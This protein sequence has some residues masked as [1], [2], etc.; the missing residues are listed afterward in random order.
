M[1]K[2]ENNGAAM[3][4]DLS[5]VL[6]ADNNLFTR[7]QYHTHDADGFANEVFILVNGGS[8]TR[9]IRLGG[10]GGDD[11]TIPCLTSS[12]S[13]DTTTPF[14]FMGKGEFQQLLDGSDEAH[15]Q[16][17]TSDNN[18]TTRLNSC[19]VGATNTKEDAVVMEG[20]SS[21]YLLFPT[22]VFRIGLSFSA[23][24]SKRLSLSV[25]LVRSW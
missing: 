24:G 14:T 5:R 12:S 19:V 8:G 15:I 20:R 1:A 7:N 2:V 21:K 25:L 22:Q 9:V 4:H 11:R 23:M 10:V 16:P 13:S 17:T 6:V 3:V 18:I